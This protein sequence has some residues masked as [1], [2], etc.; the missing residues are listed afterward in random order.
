MHRIVTAKD[1]AVQAPARK[2]GCR[3]NRAGRGAPGLIDQVQSGQVIT[4]QPVAV[5]EQ[6]AVVAQ[7]PAPVIVEERQSLGAAPAPAEPA[8]MA[9]K[10]DRG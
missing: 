1:A 2:I 3:R 4:E 6:P 8:P 10:A 5:V 9:P 7:A